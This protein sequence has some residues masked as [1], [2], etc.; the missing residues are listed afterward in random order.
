MKKVIAIGLVRHRPADW[1][2][3]LCP[4]I[5][6]A[7][8]SLIGQPLYLGAGIAAAFMAAIGYRITGKAAMLRQLLAVVL[9][10]VATIF[11]L[12]VGAASAGDL[13]RPIAAAMPIVAAVGVLISLATLV[14]LFAVTPP[15]RRPTAHGQ[16]A[17]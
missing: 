1:I 6:F 14:F 5:P 15:K 10:V 17:L 2:A 11:A 12:T 3:F 4:L 16:I 13:A 9:L 7:G 8:V